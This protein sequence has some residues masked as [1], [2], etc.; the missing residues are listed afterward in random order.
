M[1]EEKNA[2]VMFGAAHQLYDATLIP[3]CRF[4]VVGPTSGKNLLRPIRSLILAHS[5]SLT[6]QRTIA[7]PKFI[8]CMGGIVSS[9]RGM[10]DDGDVVMHT[11]CRI[12]RSIRSRWIW[13][14]GQVA[15]SFML[16]GR[17][18]LSIGRG[19]RALI[20]CKRK[21]QQNCFDVCAH[22]FSSSIHTYTRAH[23]CWEQ[24]KTFTHT[25]ISLLRT[26]LKLVRASECACVLRIIMIRLA[27][28]V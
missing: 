12:H 7:A 9:V 10:N 21:T 23:I 6:L 2:R 22:K 5:H 1:G 15:N 17:K 13:N 16:K 24:T 27:V 18:W 28:H 3:Y 25:H 8:G 11:H 20:Y 26:C 4:F 19:A 14:D